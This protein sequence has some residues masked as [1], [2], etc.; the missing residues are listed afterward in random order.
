MNKWKLLLAGGVLCVTGQFAFAG[1]PEVPPPGHHT[2]FVGLGGGYNHIRAQSTSA[3]YIP[4]TTDND[5]FT[6]SHSIFGLAPVGQL[7]YEYFTGTGGFY[8]LKGIY[9]FANKNASYIAPFDMQTT[10]EALSVIDALFEAGFCF[11]RNAVY[12]ELGYAALF[13]NTILRAPSDGGFVLG[14]RHQTLNGGVM[15]IGF[16]HYFGNISVDAAYSYTI[17]SDPT[18][19]STP[20][21]GTTEFVSNQLNRVTAQD[22]LFT[23]NYNFNF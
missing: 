20:I 21:A 1:G 14:N 9:Y 10:F 8:G 15:G 13:T 4:F 16:R 3:I 19:F 7:G 11:H 23:V 18:P 22:I 2:V 5:Q 6:D 17:F 12:L